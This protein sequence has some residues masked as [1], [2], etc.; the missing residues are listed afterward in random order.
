MHNRKKYKG[1]K[2][3]DEMTEPIA[4][5]FHIDGDIGRKSHLAGCCSI[6]ANLIVLGIVGLMAKALILN[7]NPYI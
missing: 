1:L 7:E 4:N 2:N 5:M 3:F 6:F